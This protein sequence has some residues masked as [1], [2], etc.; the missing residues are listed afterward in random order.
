LREVVCSLPVCNHKLSL[1]FPLAVSAANQQPN[2]LDGCMWRH[3]CGRAWARVCS[4][5]K[6]ILGSSSGAGMSA[7]ISPS[8]RSDALIIGYCGTGVRARGESLTRCQWCSSSPTRMSRL[9]RASGLPIGHSMCAGEHS[10]KRWQPLLGQAACAISSPGTER[11]ARD[12]ARLL[13]D[14]L[15]LHGYS[16]VDGL[17]EN[18]RSAA[19]YLAQQEFEAIVD[20]FFAQPQTSVRGWERA[21]D[22]QTRIDD[23]MPRRARRRSTIAGLGKVAARWSSSAVI[24]LP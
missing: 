24:R 15:G 23:P 16:V 22:A 17:G 13:A 12:A 4:A 18:D 3:A 10:C 1:S 11:K 9:I 5:N 21:A 14:G 19:G 2:S 7:R 8:S 20:A 6:A